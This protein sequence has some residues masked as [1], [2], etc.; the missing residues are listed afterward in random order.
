MNTATISEKN[1][2]NHSA[3]LG[4]RSGEQENTRTETTGKHAEGPVAKA[5]EKQTAKLPSDLFLW[6]AVG[7]I[8]ASASFQIAGKKQTSNFIGQWAPTLL[9]LGLYNKLVK[10]QG[11]ES[12]SV[13]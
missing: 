10:L 2:A 5:I 1:Q 13:A 7:A 12:R 8:G 9:I 3:H 11:S 6:L 4:D